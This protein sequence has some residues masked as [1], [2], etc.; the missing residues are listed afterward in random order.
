[1]MYIYIYINTIDTIQ[2]NISESIL[3]SLIK[4]IIAIG[5]ESFHYLILH[6]ASISTYNFVKKTKQTIIIA[7]NN[8]SLVI[9]TNN[10]QEVASTDYYFQLN[11]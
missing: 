10:N 1:M 8:N 4:A 6:S 2:I 5:Q 3:G 9:P 11:Q 7:T